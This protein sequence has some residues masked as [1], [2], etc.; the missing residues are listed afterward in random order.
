VSSS[1]TISIWKSTTLNKMAISKFSL[2][3]FQEKGGVEGVLVG[4]QSLST[5]KKGTSHSN[6]QLNEPFRSFYDNFF[7]T[8]C[9][10]LKEKNN[11]RYIVPTSFLYALMA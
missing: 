7:D 1:E 11:K 2:D 9:P 8:K 4:F 6:F 5:I 3:V 10:D